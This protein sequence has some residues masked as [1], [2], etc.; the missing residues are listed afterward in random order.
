MG[1]LLSLVTCLITAVSCFPG[2]AGATG[3]P[4]ANGQP[5]WGTAAVH[6]PVLPWPGEDQWASYSH[7]GVPIVDKRIADPSNGGRAPQN[8]ANVSSSCTS[9]NPDQ[10]TPSVAWM[11]SGSGANQTLFFRWR[12]EQIPNT[13]ATGPTLQPASSVDPYFAAQWTVLIDIDGD[14]FREFA[15]N[16]AGMSGAPAA[17][18]DVL[19]SIYSNTRSQTLDYEGNPLV[20]LLFHQPTAFMQNG[21]PDADYILNFHNTRTPDTSW[22]NGSAERVWDY[23][24]TRVQDVSTDS[25]KEFIV[26]YQIPLAMLDAT[27]VGGPKITE[28]TP[29]CMA[30][31]TANSNENPLQKDVAFD[32]TKAFTPEDCVPCGDL[33]TPNGAYVFQ[34]VVETISASGCGTT[35]LQARVR[36][37]IK[38]DCSTTLTGGAAGVRFYSWWDRN[39]NGVADD[40]GSSWTLAGAGTVDPADPSLFTLSWSTGA[41][42]A[43]QYLIGVQATDSEGHV[44]YSYL[45]YGQPPLPADPGPLTADP[46]P[47]T[48]ANP[49]VPGVV[50]ALFLNTCG[51]KA[52]LAKTVSP[53]FTSAGAN[54]TF[55]LTVTNSTT[56]PFTVSSITDA[57][58]AGFSFQ[59]A[60]AE[61]GTLTGIVTRPANNATGN[62]VWTL[63]GAGAT[64]AAAGSKTFTFT[65]RVS[66][67]AGTY[68]NTATAATSNVDWPSITSNPVDIGVGA[69]RLTIAKTANTYAF[70]AGETV[71]YAITYANDSP[72]N[73]TGV[74][75]TDTLPPGLSFISASGG[76]SYDVTSRVI[77]WNLPN[78]NSLEGPYTVTVSATIEKTASTRTVNTATIDAAETAPASATAT[79]FVNTPMKIQKSSNVSIVYPG[80]A[81]DQ[82]VYTIDYRNA[83]T[84]ALTGVTI[85]D[86]TPPGF[87]YV[88]HSTTAPFTGVAAEI[89]GDGYGDDDGTCETAEPCRITW[90]AATLAAGAAGSVTLT[91]RVDNPY[92]MSPYADN[93]ATMASNEAPSVSDDALVGVYN[94]SGICEATFFHN[95]TTDV[96]FDGTHFTS[97]TI[98]PLA[99]DTGSGVLIT[100]PS[101]PGWIEAVRFYGTPSSADEPL[102]DTI[103]SRMYIDRSAGSAIWLRG[104]VY[105]YDP[106]TGSRTQLG[107]ATAK[108]QGSQRGLH[109]FTITRSGTLLAGHRLLWVYEAQ[110]DHAAKTEQLLFQFDGTVANTVS[111]TTPATFANSHALLCINRPSLIVRKTVDRSTAVAGDTLRYTVTVTNLGTA[112]ATGSVVVDN[113][114]AA[115]TLVTAGATRPA[116]NG[117]LLT[118]GVDF[119]CAGQ[120][121]TF[122][123]N[124]AGQ[125]SGV[126]A[127]AA[128]ATLVLNATVNNPIPAGTNPL[129]NYVTASATGTDPES[130]AVS[131]SVGLPNTPNVTLMKAA[132]KTRLIPGDVVTFSVLAVNTGIGNAASVVV[133]DVLP[134]SAALTYVPGSIAY[135]G[136]SRTDA[137]DADNASY[138]AA[139]RTV[140]ANLGALA[141]G[142]TVTITFRMQVAAVLPAGVTE[143]TN[144]AT[145]TEATTTPGN[146][147]T[148][149]VALSAN[150]NLQIT[151]T[152]SPAAGPVQP[153]STLQYTM[154]VANVG[155]GTATG[156][157]LADPIPAN[158]AYLP[159]TILFQGAAQ[160]DA[161]D[162]DTASFDGVLRRTLFSIGSLL[163]GETRTMSFSARVADPLASGTTTV[164]NT[165]TAT[166]PDTAGKSATASV[167]AA[168]A[169]ALS[170]SKSAPVVVAYPLTTLAVASPAPGANQVTVTSARFLNPND[171]VVLGAVGYK[172]TAVDYAL[173]VVTLDKAV[174][175]FAAG[176]GVVPTVKYQFSYSNT[177]HAAATGV[178][179]RDTFVP[180]MNFLS[181]Y[182][183]AGCVA[184][185]PVNCTVGTVAAGATGLVTLR[186]YPSAAGT[187][188]NFGMLFSSELN[189]ITS[190]VVTTAVGG[191]EVGKT[192]STPAIVNDPA[193]GTPEIG[194]YAITLKSQLP[195]YAATVSELIDVLPV[196]FTYRAPVS[197]TNGSC[198]GTPAVGSIVPR[199]TGCIVNQNQTM[200]I[201]FTV[202]VGQSVSAGTYQNSVTATVEGNIHV[203]PF[204]ELATTAEDVT[205][206]IP[207]DVAVSVAVTSAPAPCAG[208]PAL[209]C[210]TYTLSARNLGTSQ[211]TAVVVNDTGG[212]YLAWPPVDHTFVSAAA[213]SQGSFDGATGTWTVGTLPA[214]VAP[215]TQTTATLAVTFSVN[216]LASTVTNFAVITAANDSNPANNRSSASLVPTLV[217]LSG[218]DAF[219]VDGLVVVQWATSSQVGTGGF[220][221]SRFDADGS[222]RPV[223]PRLLPALLGAP[224][225]GTYRYGDADALPGEA[226]T[227]RLDEVEYNGTTRTHG[228]FA[229]RAVTADRFLLEGEIPLPGGFVRLPRPG[230]SSRLGRPA[231]PAAGAPASPATAAG[232]ATAAAPPAR[233]LKITVTEPGLYFVSAAR[234]A[235]LTGVRES[236]VRTTI[237]WARYALSS[238]GRPVAYLRAPG[239]RGLTFYGQGIDSVY[240]SANVYRLAPGTGT[241]MP[242]A[243]GTAPAAGEVSDFTDLLHVEEDLTPLTEAFMQPEEDFWMWGYAFAGDPDL[244]TFRTTFSL[245]APPHGTADAQLTLS[246]RGFSSTG[247]SP[248]H[249]ALVRLNGAPVGELSWAG[250]ARQA[251][252]FPV[253]PSLLAPRANTLEVEAA[254]LDG[255]PFSVFFVDS[256]DL[257]YRRRAEA[258]GES[259]H[260]Q[261]PSPEPLTVGGFSSRPSLVLDVSDPFRPRLNR[262]V[263]TTFVETEGRW[264]VTLAPGKRETRTFV[265][266]AD[267]VRTARVEGFPPATLRR[268]DQGARYLVIAP[269]SLGPAAASFAAYRRSQRLAARVIPLEAVYDEFGHG[270][271][272][273]RAIRSFLRYALE[274]WVVRPHYVLLLGDGSYDYR[275]LLGFGESRV[276]VLLASTP[277]GLFPADNALADFNGDHVPEIAIGRIPALSNG[278]AEDVL[279]KIKAAERLVSKRVVL[280]TDDADEAGS[281]P[282]DSR[283]LAALLPPTRQARAISLEFL[284]PAAARTSLAWE[285][286]RGAALVNYIGHGGLATLAAEGLVTAGDAPNLTSE[287]RLPVLSAFTCMA[288]LFANPGYDS[289]AEALLLSPGS[290]ALAVWS[291]AGA[292]YNDLA[293]TLNAE[294][295]RNLFP[296]RPVRLGDAVRRALA[297]YRDAGLDPFMMDIYNL[298]GDPALVLP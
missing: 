23:G 153:G 132:D 74:V 4:G 291:P 260:L 150:P 131:T 240:G 22:P 187:Y 179:I 69:P 222:W 24:S 284:A 83:G 287:G 136:A 84:S 11:F 279:A 245:P 261:P 223:T 129:T 35:T 102:S 210:V 289:L 213:P 122:P 159:G 290:G 195:N 73:T 155:G 13:Y 107:Q 265:A 278:E 105:D 70:N 56:A 51:A 19:Q 194:S 162:G 285:W 256:F 37:A 43:G 177:G 165:A 27:S 202:D 280:L 2:E 234:I 89:I 281:F 106:I 212:D 154:T 264:R 208:N 191:L 124:S 220:H 14:G 42:N 128:A 139:T 182:S 36:D 189:S 204:D 172:V 48:F 176:T 34:P 227:Y 209:T 45:S 5:Y 114:P 108:F 151:K 219:A 135:N 170:I 26:D 12:V 185:V 235:A 273:P 169:P 6:F 25:C 225:G 193:N 267:G 65:A 103:E 94:S 229:V 1:K 258:A 292:S 118:L 168:A 85:T 147:N 274:R 32:G 31:V 157:L 156:V 78:L 98:S 148:V 33:M 296:G 199:W 197:I 77:T 55:T 3:G 198:T 57:L 167:T 62:V 242:A 134:N 251:A 21:G 237:T 86:A 196:G 174:P 63:A 58:P 28:Q 243:T 71:V 263:T 250:T 175:V 238:Q 252:V 295:F 96:G 253:D 93:V 247:V 87:F 126:I 269:R 66:A 144:T 90:S 203:L 115:V 142:Q 7:A 178:V 30:F 104:T 17:W 46:G 184:G 101:T 158:T 61:G 79:I 259:L 111:G 244:G 117:T 181:A 241:L 68:A 49:P 123:V 80:G 298:L 59:A 268:T 226:L 9:A 201:A 145:A 97:D 40:A 44:T 215:A 8:Y 113:L 91:L 233:A 277:N 88:S 297:A 109:T 272:T 112:S 228:P 18:I 249:R 275:D 221:L 173:N 116:L 146:S 67:N 110:T 20:N 294:L 246:L 95:E 262:A 130:D 100:A 190:N 207:N 60:P 192:T 141:P 206:T 41:L 143:L 50:S 231:A 138:T 211:A 293:K 270:L 200:T 224:Q 133:S 137:A 164:A 236:E 282:A 276:P 47:G 81:P 271:A 76:G 149:T 53:S 125:A 288:G 15:A 171:V 248:E 140:S 232:L 214:A 54:V 29:M 286:S 283:E 266:S 163:K 188:T 160:T 216:T 186:A 10:Q 52:A 230:S 39:A 161:A 64:V 16:I 120:V 152:S 255:V 127:P 217:T 257:A 205:V 38:I 239:G 92:A 119:T 82:V 166:S 254:L 121:C 180:G 75:L 99:T 183:S 218:F 72:V